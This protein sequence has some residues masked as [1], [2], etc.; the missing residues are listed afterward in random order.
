MV[1]Q[2]DESAADENGDES[3]GEGGM[4]RGVRFFAEADAAFETV[5][6]LH[7]YLGGDTPPTG[8]L[9]NYDC[10]RVWGSEWFVH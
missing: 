9:F 8:K 5:G 2:E 10:L 6:I 7:E 1:C 4:R 3:A